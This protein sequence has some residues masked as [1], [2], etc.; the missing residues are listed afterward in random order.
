MNR[1][2]MAHRC[3]AS[4]RP[5]GRVSALSALALAI[6]LGACDRGEGYKA[7]H[8]PFFG[9]YSGRQGAPVLLSNAEWWHGFQDPALDQ[10]V[11]QALSE[12]LTLAAAKERVIEARAQERGI[13]GRAALSSSVKGVQQGET[14]GS[15]TSTTEGDLGFSWLL[16]PYGERRASKAAAAARVEATDAEADAARLLVLYNLC[17]AYVDLRYQERLLSLRQQEIANRT[18]TLSL[19]QSL[20]DTSSGTKLDVTRTRAELAQAQG[21]LPMI[22]AAIRVQQNQIAVLTGRQPGASGPETTTGKGIPQARMSADVGIPAD[23]LRNR[24]DIRIAERQY[25]AAVSE[26][27]VAEA[28]LYPR[29]S[30]TGAISLTTVHKGATSHDYYFGPTVD[31]PAIPNTRTKA[32][33]EATQSAARQAHITWKATVL[34]ALMEVENALVEY[35]GSR[36]ARAATERSLKLYREAQGMTR[37]LVKSGGATVGD[38]IDADQSVTSASNSLAQM[39]RQQALDFIALNVRLGSGSAAGEAPAPAA[40][41]PAAASGG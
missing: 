22:Q 35:D 40:P 9:S 29:L 39:Q 15:V 25:Y 21:E 17:N 36:R 23:L 27:T 41:P 37:D 26:I 34:T 24:P 10:L 2:R 3:Q 6:A 18:S 12:N 5:M 7:P 28:D 38:L 16:D 30:L 11:A 20:F 14:G 32:G 31:L 13:P 8:F 4:H 19:A 1:T 33:V